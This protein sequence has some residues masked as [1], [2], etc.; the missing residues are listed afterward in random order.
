MRAK[1]FALIVAIALLIPQ[2]VDGTQAASDEEPELLTLARQ[3][4]EELSPADEKLFRAVAKGELANYSAGAKEK[5]DPAKAPEWS[6]ERVLKSDRIAWLCT[7]PRASR[8]VTHR[9]IG[10]KGARIDGVLELR[11]A[12]IPFPLYLERCALPAGLNLLHGEILGLNL[13]GTHSGPIVAEGLKT[14]A[15]V[16][17]HNGFKAKGEVSLQDAIIRGRLSCAD[18]RFI[19]LGGKALLANGIDVGGSVLLR[20]GFWAQGEVNLVRAK[21]GGCLD[22]TGGKFINPKG[23]ALNADGLRVEGDIFLRNEFEAEGVVDFKGARIS[24][25]LVWKDALWPTKVTMDLRSATIGT[26]WDNKPTW[27]QSGRIFLHGLVY[28]EI[29]DLA[30]LDIQ[31]RIEWLRRQP[32]QP[33]R[34]QPYEQLAAVLRK[35]GHEEDARR[36]LIAKE[37]D[38]ARLTRM[39]V[40]KRCG[41]ALLGLV[42]GYG[43]RPWRAFWIGLVVVAVGSV[44]FGIGSRN[45]LLTPT[46]KEGYASE[47]AEDHQVY[48]PKF[49]TVVYS[50]DAFVPL[51]V[52]HQASYWLP[53]ATRGKELSKLKW[54]RL[55]TG[56]LLRLYLWFHI[57]L[58][59]VLSTLF[60]VGLSGL[61]RT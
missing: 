17:L 52:L 9:G 34:P 43:Y 60:V 50:L 24:G 8:L 41:H 26:L 23:T 13:K 39:P 49:N 18:G 57:I 1:T 59:W 15:G 36:I 2:P 42:V 38:R 47:G 5:D 14:V 37:K 19:K 53:N 11:F 58:G 46:K 21:I 55:R 6:E 22:C 3:R 48:Y 51:I 45:G 27:P 30:L 32:T 56:G 4:F 40:L 33:F 35:A 7:D 44:L 31:D 12:K 29:Y 54:F 61:I 10:V 16:F 28:N 20:D 25:Y